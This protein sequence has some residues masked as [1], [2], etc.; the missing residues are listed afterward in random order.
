MDAAC[1]E[2]GYRPRLEADVVRQAVDEPGI[3][4]GSE[5]AVVEIA[6]NPPVGAEVVMFAQA[7][8][9]VAADLDARFTGYAI[10]DR[11]LIARAGPL[12]YHDSTELVAHDHRGADVV[13]DG[14]VKDVQV[15]SANAARLYLDLHLRRTGRLLLDLAKLHEPAAP[16]V[17]YNSL[18]LRVSSSPT[19]G[20]ART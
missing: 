1:Q 3:D 18:H 2:F 13:V 5:A 11:D 6:H 15:G 16:P 10:A 12:F 9:A 8:G 7:V 4:V 17:L 19:T 20:F 14:V